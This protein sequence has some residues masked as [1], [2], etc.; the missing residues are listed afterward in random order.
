[1]ETKELLAGQAA[2][3]EEQ[4]RLN[5]IG[6]EGGILCANKTN[7]AGSNLPK[8]CQDFNSWLNA[9]LW[10][11]CFVERD[12]LLWK[13]KSVITLEQQLNFACMTQQEVDHLACIVKKEEDGTWRTTPAARTCECESSFVT[14]EKKFWRV[15]WLPIGLIP[16]MKCLNWIAC[17]VFTVLKIKA[18][19]ELTHLG[20][21]TWL[22]CKKWQAVIGYNGMS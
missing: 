2:K 9:M 14:F 6:V 22:V 21:F 16:Q 20:V 1:M 19:R 13:K 8:T 15:S 18:D 11:L 7:R 12:I 10:P 3:L 4:K 17:Y 5:C